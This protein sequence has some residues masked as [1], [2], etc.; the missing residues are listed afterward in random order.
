MGFRLQIGKTV[1]FLQRGILGYETDVLTFSQAGEDI[2]IRNFFYQRLESGEL[3]SYLDIGAYHPFRESNTYYLYRCGW[4]GV[5]VDARPGI[6]A[7]FHKYRPR[8]TTV[9]AA[10]S[11]K[12]GEIEYFCF[13]ESP[14]LNTSS[15]EYVRQLG[16][17]DGVSRAI[18]VPTR[19]MDSILHEH[20]GKAKQVE[21]LSMDIEGSEEDALLSN[22]WERY[23]F[24]LVA[25]EIYGN[26]LNEISNTPVSRLLAANGYEMFARVILSAPGVNTV[27]FTDIA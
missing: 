2:L 8:D 15:S 12:E 5:N 22:D 19:R 6:K 25:I 20:F 14:S 4:R 21:F 23:R 7:L 26:T 3:G 10:V 11:C 24:K 1:K 16:T 18:K 9:E 17:E 27:F 13:D